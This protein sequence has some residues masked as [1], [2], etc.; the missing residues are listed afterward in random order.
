MALALNKSDLPSA[1]AYIKEIQSK[2][3]IHGAHVGVSMS[4]HSEMAFIR[5]H[6]IASSSQSTGSNN[7]L[8]SGRVFDCLQSA[9]SLRQPVL[10]FPVND[11]VTYEPLPGLQNH[12]TR[13]ASLPNHGFITCVCA[14]GGIA[15]SHWNNERKMYI[16]STKSDAK[17]ALRD[18]IMMKQNSTV[19]DVFRSLKGMSVLE[20]GEYLIEFLYVITHSYLILQ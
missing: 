10:V 7:G 11:F 18:M 19:E 20:G 2:L 12:A 4:A 1:Q 13:D 5:H 6:L 16:P 9:M 3:P 8:T 17:P 15:P 14:S